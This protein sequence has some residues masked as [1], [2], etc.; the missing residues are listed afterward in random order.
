MKIF[1]LAIGLLFSSLASAECSNNLVNLG[2]L[3]GGYSHHTSTK[4]AP[5]GGYLEDHRMRGI[6]IFH[7]RC[8]IRLGLSTAKFLDS[9]GEDSWLIAG[10]VEY[11]TEVAKHLELSIG[12]GASKVRTSYFHDIMAIPFIKISVPLFKINDNDIGIYVKVSNQPNRVHTDGVI[13][14]TVGFQLLT[15]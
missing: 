9:F 8:G 7:N 10:T 4:F 3:A 15:F 6:E 5:D 14:A 11:S 13:A 2:V 1:I 12:I